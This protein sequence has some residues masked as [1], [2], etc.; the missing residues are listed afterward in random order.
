M[1]LCNFLK[2]RGFER[3]ALKIQNWRLGND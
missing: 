1:E 3:I 2:E